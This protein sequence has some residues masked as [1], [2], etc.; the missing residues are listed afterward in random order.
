MT[1]FHCL[2]FP[3]SPPTDRCQSKSWVIEATVPR[4]PRQMAAVIPEYGVSVCV[5]GRLPC[6]VAFCVSSSVHCVIS[7]GGVSV[8]V[9][10]APPP[11][12]LA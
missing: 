9:L 2:I 4:P 7:V 5:A 8:D 6:G 3:V 12:Q 10:F 1:S 11:P